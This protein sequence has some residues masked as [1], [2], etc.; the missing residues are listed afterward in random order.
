MKTVWIVLLLLLGCGLLMGLTGCGGKKYQVDYCGSKDL[1]NNAKNSY[2]AGTTV[3]LYFDAI[4]TDTDYS[5][6]LDGEPIRFTY[7]QKKGFVI[8][9]VM[10]DHDVKLECNTVNSMSFQ[11]R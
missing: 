8:R 5:F 3:T 9:F 1:Y 6:C 2:R 10:P 11:N 4:A 7:D